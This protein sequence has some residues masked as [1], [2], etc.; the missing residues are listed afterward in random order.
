MDRRVA[1]VTGITG[2]EGA[3]L[4]EML[5]DRGYAVHGLVPRA[6][7][8]NTGRIEHLICAQAHAAAANAVVPDHGAC[9]F[10]PFDG[11]VGDGAH[12]GVLRLHY[13]QWCDASS[14]AQLV[15]ATRPHEIYDLALA[16]SAAQAAQL[17]AAAE[18]LAD[19]TLSSANASSAHGSVAS[20]PRKRGRE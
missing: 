3:R 7:Y 5:L 15:A 1:V 19:N 9:R 17:G 20:Q 16:H 12:R 10:S 18:C 13:P 2:E 11:R 4:A 6:S 14:L 8:Y